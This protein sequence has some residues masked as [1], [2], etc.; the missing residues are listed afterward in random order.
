M[1]NPDLCTE[2]AIAGPVHA[3]YARVR[4]DG[5]PDPVFD[6]HV[7]DRDIRLVLPEAA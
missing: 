1:P 4:D 2:E 3:F 5:L 6:R 7:H